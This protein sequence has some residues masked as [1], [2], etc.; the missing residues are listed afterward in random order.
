MVRIAEEERPISVDALRAD[1]AESRLRE[2][3]LAEK[4]SELKDSIDAG[5][6]DADKDAAV[7]RAMETQRASQA[8]IKSL[9]SE[10][11]ALQTKLRMM[12]AH[13]AFA[14]SDEDDARRALE[15]A[16]MLF[17]LAMTLLVFLGVS[18]WAGWTDVIG[19]VARSKLGDGGGECRAT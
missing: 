19:W 18:E 3:K 16:M 2:M 15:S 12:E 8:T 13:K 7:K 1:L 4:V 5:A 9:E 6:G 11:R 10:V 17:A 14:A